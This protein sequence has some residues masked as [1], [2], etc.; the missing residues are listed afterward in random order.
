MACMDVTMFLKGLVDVTSPVVSS[1]GVLV[2]GLCSL[3]RSKDANEYI[4]RASAVFPH[5]VNLAA[6]TDHFSSLNTKP[7]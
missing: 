4:G 3:I 6:M 1:A 5:K 7:A 2:E